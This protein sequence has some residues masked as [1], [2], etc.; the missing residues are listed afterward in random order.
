MPLAIWIENKI[1]KLERK[2]EKRFTSENKLSNFGLKIQQNKA[3]SAREIMAEKIPEIA[4][5]AKK[6]PRINQFEA[7]TSRWI[8]ISSFWFI[9]ASL[10]VL[11]VIKIATRDRIMLAKMPAVLRPL[12]SAETL[13][14]IGLLW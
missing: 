2:S 3:K 9:I 10:I 4:P 1:Q 6:G 13:S 11:K 5:C 14:I 12:V 8:E 7:P